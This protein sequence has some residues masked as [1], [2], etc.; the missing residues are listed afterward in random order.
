MKKF[1]AVLSVFVCFSLRSMEPSDLQNVIENIREAA[2]AAGGDDERL[3]RLAL[4]AAVT[5][6]KRGQMPGDL[7]LFAVPDDTKAIIH[8]VA[9]GEILTDASVLSGEQ[10]RKDC[11]DY[12]LA[13]GRMF[14]G[15][16]PCVGEVTDATVDYIVDRSLE[17]NLEHEEDCMNESMHVLEL[18]RTCETS[19]HV[20]GFVST[21]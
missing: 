20:Q 15:Y 18:I 16:I 11:K 1:L 9:T 7:G 21:P 3:E 12:F 4:V 14:G 10:L 5:E 17:A 6:F 2:R 8:Y 19:Q 13:Q